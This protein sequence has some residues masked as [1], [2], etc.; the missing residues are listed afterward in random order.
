MHDAQAKSWGLWGDYLEGLFTKDPRNLQLGIS[1]I[2]AFMHACRHNQESKARKY[3]A[4]ILWLLMYDDDKGALADTVDKYCI[5]V[6]PIQWLPWVPQLLVS[7]GRH[8]GKM[9]INLLNQVGRMYPQA[10]YF[11]IRTLYLTLKVEQR[12]KVRSNEQNV[13]AAVAQSMISNAAKSPQ[14][15]EGSPSAGESVPNVTQQPQASQPEAQAIKATP[16][17]WRCSR[18]M[19][20]QRDLHPTILSNLEGIIDQVRAHH[21]IYYLKHNNTY[22]F[23]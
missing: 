9:I 10:V 12:E 6:P 4:K 20:M 15:V 8:D 23:L 11:P 3:I 19:H 5:G 14:R 18:I 22:G 17:M 21:V 16:S 2:T 13:A 7:L 1:A